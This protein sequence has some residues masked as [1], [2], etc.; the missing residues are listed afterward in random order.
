[1]R[2]RELFGVAVRVIGFWLLTEAGYSGF[3]AIMKSQTGIGSANIT[4]TEHA[5]F[6]FYYV[7]LGTVILLLADPIVWVIYGLPP[8][9]T[10]LDQG[11]GPSSKLDHGN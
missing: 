1:M 9:S 8:K 5:A 2:A 7:V 11:V 6:A 10:M 4:P 3:W